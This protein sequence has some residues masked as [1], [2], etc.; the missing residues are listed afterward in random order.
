LGRGVAKI[1]NLVRKGK[2][3]KEEEEGLKGF[4]VETMSPS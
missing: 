1:V 3:K 2:G 4:F